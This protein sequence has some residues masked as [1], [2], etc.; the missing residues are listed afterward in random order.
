MKLTESGFQIP[1]KAR[2]GGI[3][4]SIK[5]RMLQNRSFRLQRSKGT[6]SP[7]IKKVSEKADANHHKV[8]ETWSR[9]KK[10]SSPHTCTEPGRDGFSP[11]QDYADGSTL[12]EEAKLLL[13]Q[14][15]AHSQLGATVLKKEIVENESTQSPYNPLKRTAG[16]LCKD[17][18]QMES[19]EEEDS[20]DA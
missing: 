4:L 2:R 3:G 1:M 6:S 9:N 10:S 11:S 17:S 18:K 7:Q 5:H 16:G 14:F 13:H 8:P 19:C 20:V 12:D 15:L